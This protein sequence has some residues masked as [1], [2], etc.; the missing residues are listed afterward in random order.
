MV[1]VQHLIKGLITDRIVGHTEIHS[2][3]SYATKRLL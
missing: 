3:E 2:S 1:K